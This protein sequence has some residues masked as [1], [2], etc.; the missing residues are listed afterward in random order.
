MSDSWGCD[1]LNRKT[2]VHIIEKN[3][4]VFHINDGEYEIWTNQQMSIH[5]SV[6][7]EKAFWIFLEDELG[8]V[9][10]Y[11]RGNLNEISLLT[12]KE[13]LFEIVFKNDIFVQSRY[14][15]KG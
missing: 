5:L 12:F 13:D 15:K 8:G 9:D 7:D 1:R 3:G 11:T 14:V 2:F 4:F 6:N 10:F